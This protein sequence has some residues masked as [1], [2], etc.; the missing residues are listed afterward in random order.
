VVGPELNKRLID[1]ET[2]KSVHINIT[3]S[4]H[5]DLRI[6]LLKRGLSMQIVFDRIASL[7]CDADPAL[8]R[9]LD[10][11]ETEKREG[12]LKQVTKSDSESIFEL[13]ESENPFEGFI[14]LKET[15][16]E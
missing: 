7:I 11:L 4:T 9:M 8:V 10:Q 5:S 6:L 1:Y 15:P 3:K 13:I 16:D 2:R 14:D 12:L